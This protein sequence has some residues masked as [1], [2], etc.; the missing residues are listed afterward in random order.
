[1]ED[2]SFI[3]SD[4]HRQ[5]IFY[6]GK[7]VMAPQDINKTE[8]DEFREGICVLRKIIAVSCDM[9]I[10]IIVLCWKTECSYCSNWHKNSRVG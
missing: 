2:Y 7:K 10:K 9:I 8:Y 5:K 1:M 4:V 6:E 3:D